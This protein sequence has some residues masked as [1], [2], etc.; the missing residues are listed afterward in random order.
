MEANPERWQQSYLCSG[1]TAVFDVGGH[2]WTTGLPARFE[3][4]PRG[5]HIRAAG[6]LITHATV[7]PLQLDD[8]VYTFL[9]MGSVDEARE[10]TR[11]V[12]EMGATAAKVWYLGA[13]P[14]R[15]A[16]L[17]AGPRPLLRAWRRGGHG[18]G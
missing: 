12:A 10:S 13:G 1:I 2:P 4:D 14:P 7:P 5:T 18:G 15:Q 3:N 9:P 17:D 16:E 11:Q 8:E 6:P